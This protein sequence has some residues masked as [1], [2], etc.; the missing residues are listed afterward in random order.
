MDNNDDYIIQSGCI[1][2]MIGDK[3]MFIIMEKCDVGK[4]IFNNGSPFVIRGK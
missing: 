2:H 4:I 1:D 3:N